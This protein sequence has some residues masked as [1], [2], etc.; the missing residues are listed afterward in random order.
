[1]ERIMR[2]F[3][4]AKDTGLTISRAEK[5]FNVEVRPLD[6]DASKLLFPDRLISVEGDHDDV[7]RFFDKLCPGI[8]SEEQR[9]SLGI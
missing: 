8:L 2:Q 3:Y 9:N 5:L 6:H 7:Y 4:V 1:M